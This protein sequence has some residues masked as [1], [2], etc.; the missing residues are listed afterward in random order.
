MLRAW[1]SRF[2]SMELEEPLGGDHVASC[3]SLQIAMFFDAN[4]SRVSWHPIPSQKL[5]LN[6]WPKLEG[7]DGGSGE[8]GKPSLVKAVEDL[9]VSG[10][11]D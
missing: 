9:D 7:A 8:D 10:V 6:C 3:F 1:S 11:S 4:K 2:R 5:F